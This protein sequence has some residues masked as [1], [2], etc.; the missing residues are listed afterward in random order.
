[1]VADGVVKALRRQ[2]AMLAEHQIGVT[3]SA[4]VALFDGLTN[5]EIMAAAADLAMYE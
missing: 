1:V 3:A 2:T 4:G 5:I